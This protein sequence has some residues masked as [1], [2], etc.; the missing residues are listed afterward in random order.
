MAPKGKTIL[1][2]L[3]SSASTGFFYITKKNPTNIQHKMAFR[4]YDPIVQQH[5]LFQ[6]AKLV[7][8]RGGRRAGK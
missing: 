5:V 8:G 6:E 3:A 1:I 7:K 4:K 2:K